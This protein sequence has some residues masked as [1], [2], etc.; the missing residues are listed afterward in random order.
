M[1]DVQ[2]KVRIDNLGRYNGK[3]IK[4]DET[5]NEVYQYGNGNN[6]KQRNNQV[7]ELYN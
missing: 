7:T 5:G 3:E 4:T 6:Y 1:T 2:G